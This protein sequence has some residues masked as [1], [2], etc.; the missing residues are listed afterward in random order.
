[1]D[2]GIVL[3][4]RIDHSNMRYGRL[5]AIEDVGFKSG[6]RMWRCLCDCGKE[7][8]TQGAMLTRGGTRSCGCLAGE[9]NKTHGKSNSETYRTYSGMKTRCLNKKHRQYSNYGGRGI[10]ICDRWIASFENFLADMGERPAG[11]TLDRKDNNGNYEPSNCRWATDT[12]QAR[13]R[14][15]NL[16][17]TYQGETL[18]MKEFAKKFNIK[19]TT[20]GRRLSAGWP[21]EKALLDP[22]KDMGRLKSKGGVTCV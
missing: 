10:T 14:S 12:E 19:R 2:G 17:L 11:M 7:I 15:S 4:K 20:L 9:N 5:I 6:K 22:V 8:V 18:C 1:M 13:N 16:F 21:I 3:I